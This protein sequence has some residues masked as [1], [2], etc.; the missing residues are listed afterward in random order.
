MNR[1]DLVQLCSVLA[2]APASLAGDGISTRAMAN[3]AL[4]ALGFGG[5]GG[6]EGPPHRGEARK[7]V[8]GSE[9][10]LRAAYRLAASGPFLRAGSPEPG[11]R[12]A[13]LEELPRE[14]TAMAAAGRP[15]RCLDD[16]EGREEL[17]RL[18]TRLAGGLPEGETPEL[19]RDR[20]RALD[21]VE[22]ARTSARAKE[23]ERRA[24]ELAEA[25]ARREAEEA[26]SKMSRE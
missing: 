11:F 2:S 26:A 20:F 18:M 14:A 16:G 21:S 5:L 15:S 17:S 9:I 25:M 19:A 22:R 13:F 10:I 23:A 4:V 1:Y 8:P 12:K 24:R 7:D 6:D 3:D